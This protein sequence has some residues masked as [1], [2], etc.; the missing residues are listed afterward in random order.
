[1]D[2]KKLLYDKKRDP[3][4]ASVGAY[5]LLRFGKLEYLHDWT[6][7][8]KNWFLWLP[9]GVAIR[10][11]HLARLGRHNEALD[12]FLELSSRG[13]PIFSDGITYVQDRLQY[14]IALG[15]KEFT[16]Q[17]LA[18]AQDLLGNLQKFIPYIDFAKPILNYTGLDPKSPDN[19]TID[20]L[21]QGNGLDVNSFLP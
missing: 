13:L 2:A 1:L 21:P 3:I 10:G 19:E 11:E 17:K 4:A 8:L 14:Y 15:D 12:T 7:N 16:P 20:I 18:L 9:D 6:D 5:T